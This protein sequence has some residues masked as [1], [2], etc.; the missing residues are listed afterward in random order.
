MLD[1]ATSALDMES[2]GAVQE[3]LERL[4][5]GRTT[6]VIAHR[7][8]AL[9]NAATIVVLD[10]GR[11]VESGSHA[12]LVEAAGLYRRM[13][14]LG[15]ATSLSGGPT[16]QVGRLATWAAGVPALLASQLAIR[17]GRPLEERVAEKAARD[18]LAAAPPAGQSAR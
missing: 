5:R 13:Y 11:V 1:E 8:A 9:R 14:S 3:A 4:T 15:K 7:F 6:L 18:R 17:V 12:Q 10:A 2:E 16:G